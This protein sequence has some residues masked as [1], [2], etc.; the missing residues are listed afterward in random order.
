MVE[1]IRLGFALI[2]TSCQVHNGYYSFANREV[3]S[4]CV[5]FL[6]ACVP[7]ESPLRLAPSDA[8]PTRRPPIGRCRHHDTWSSATG[9][10]RGA[11][12]LPPVESLGFQ[13]CVSSRER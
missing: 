13:H 9:W 2:F 12:I 8:A 5:A 6:M 1:M 4:N 11:N 10:G 3:A 7:G